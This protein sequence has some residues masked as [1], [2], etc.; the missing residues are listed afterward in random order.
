MAEYTGACQAIVGGKAATLSPMEQ[1]EDVRVGGILFEAF[2]TAG[3]IDDLV[4]RHAGR[5]SRLVFKT[6][7]HP[8]HLDYIRFLQDDLRLRERP[9]MLRNLLLNGLPHVTGDQVVICLRS[10]SPVSDKSGQLCEQD[11]TMHYRT[12]TM[13]AG[14][15]RSAAGAVTAAHV[16]AVI[17]IL[18]RGLAPRSGLLQSSEIGLALLNKSGFMDILGGRA[19][20]H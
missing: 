1:K 8:G 15:I 13:N 3:S 19:M 16:C 6:L 9:Y 7:R 12:D 2:T 4:T 11:M 5:V 18:T 20:A 10:R 14:P 17:E